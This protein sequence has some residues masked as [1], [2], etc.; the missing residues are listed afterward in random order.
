[1]EIYWAKMEILLGK[2]GNFTG[3]RWKFYWAKIEIFE[4]FS[5]NFA[6]KIK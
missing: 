2:D 3:Q 5:P 4:I 6:S 1:M